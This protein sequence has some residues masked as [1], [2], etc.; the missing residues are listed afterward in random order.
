M[1][2]PVG[3]S[4]HLRTGSAFQARCGSGVNTPDPNADHTFRQDENL[5]SDCDYSNWDGWTVKGF[6]VTTILRG[7]VMVDA[8]KWV[9][10]TGIGQFVPGRTPEDA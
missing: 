3:P 2:W 5:H 10:P 6:P 9:G 8:G 7:N 1:C 4:A